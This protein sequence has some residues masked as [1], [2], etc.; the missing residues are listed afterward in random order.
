[1]SEAECRGVTVGSTSITFVPGPLRAG[2][3]VAD[4]ETAGSTMLLSQV[5]LPCM[6][7]ADGPVDAVLRGGTNADM[8]PQ[9]D[10]T[11]RVRLRGRA[12]GF[13]GS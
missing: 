12:G 1:M 2:S 6:L 9:V 13:G 3:F 8:A 7:F 10:F 5:A 11:D 4:T